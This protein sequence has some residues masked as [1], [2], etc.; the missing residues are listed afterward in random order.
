MDEVLKENRLRV[1]RWAVAAIL[2]IVGYVA[3]AASAFIGGTPYAATIP[4]FAVMSPEEFRQIAPP[5]SPTMVVYRPVAFDPVRQTLTLRIFL[6]PDGTSGGQ[7]VGDNWQ[8]D[9]S[10]VRLI[11]NGPL[12]IAGNRGVPE[13]IFEGDPS[14]L[15][16]NLV[17]AMAGDPM[18]S[19]DLRQLA[20]STRASAS[21]NATQFSPFEIDLPTQLYG[22]AFRFRDDAFWFP[23]DS[24]GFQMSV[25]GSVRYHFEFEPLRL[26]D[27]PSQWL[28]LPIEPFPGRGNEISGRGPWSTLVDGW[29]VSYR[30]TGWLVSDFPTAPEVIS[31]SMPL[32]LI[33]VSF[34]VERPR[35]EMLLTGLFA[36]IFLV[37]MIALVIVVRSVRGGRRP[38]T[39]FGLVWAA[40]LAFAAVSLR[41]ALPGEVPYGVA[42]DWIFFFPTLLGSAL[43]TLMLASSWVTRDDFTP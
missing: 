23:F 17:E 21:A 16:K 5:N 27:E 22:R 14:V 24:Y 13:L 35:S 4:P 20:E 40:A 8:F 34:Y 36:L 6:R 33:G 10:D 19:D 15:P 9:G 11:F 30:Q 37:T 32:G 41:T 31:E 18:L 7:V 1:N 38:P 43:F 25:H 3:A 28:P 26:R 2:A 12:E 29:Q 39:G 42:F